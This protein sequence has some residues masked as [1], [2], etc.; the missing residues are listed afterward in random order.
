M[1]KTSPKDGDES[2]VVRMQSGKRPIT[3]AH[4]LRDH[5]HQIKAVFQ[6]FVN[7]HN[8]LLK[9]QQDSAQA[10]PV[11]E[12]EQTRRIRQLEEEMA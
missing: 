8:K 10:E 4:I 1:Q 12:D 3:N 7:N 5:V 9:E 6:K 11:V 2:D